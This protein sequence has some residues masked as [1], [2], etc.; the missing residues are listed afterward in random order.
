MTPNRNSPTNFRS[1]P[2]LNSCYKDDLSNAQG[3][4]ELDVDVVTHDL[5]WLLDIVATICKS[6]TTSQQISQLKLIHFTKA[7]TKIVAAMATGETDIPVLCK[8]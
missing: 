2:R 1:Y 7:N 3:D 8:A 6:C 4:T 5:E